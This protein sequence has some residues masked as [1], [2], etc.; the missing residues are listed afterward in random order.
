MQPHTISVGDCSD[1]GTDW[2]QIEV[3]DEVAMKV[4]GLIGV[5]HDRVSR[6]ILGSH[7]ANG[8]GH[9][10]RPGLRQRVLALRVAEAQ[11]SAEAAETADTQRSTLLRLHARC[12]VPSGRLS[13]KHEAC[14]VQIPQPAITVPERRPAQFET[15]AGVRSTWQHVVRVIPPHMGDSTR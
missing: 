9:T 15:S 3:E 4:R 7:E 6:R 2:K 11:S 5:A 12:S 1:M 13:C 14:Y 10:T 8:H